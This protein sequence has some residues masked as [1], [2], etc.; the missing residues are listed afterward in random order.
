MGNGCS[1]TATDNILVDECLGL[2]EAA[3]GLLEIAPNPS[4]GLFTISLAGSSD[5]EG[6]VILDAQGKTVPFELNGQTDL[7]IDLRNAEN[8]VYF[9]TG[10][11]D[12]T[13][14]MNRLVKQ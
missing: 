3:K 5:L 7:T 12:G 10:T 9:L 2:E 6:I 14:I 8:G 1:A 4:N 13:P 11:I